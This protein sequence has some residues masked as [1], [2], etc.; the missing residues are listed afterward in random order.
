MADEPPMDRRKF[1]RRGLRELL[2]PLAQVVDTAS[3]VASQVG[4]IEPPAPKPP[5]K[6]APPMPTIRPPEGETS[7]RSTSRFPTRPPQDQSSQ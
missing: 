1:F 7:V 3:Q 2:K 6:P 5:A 4:K